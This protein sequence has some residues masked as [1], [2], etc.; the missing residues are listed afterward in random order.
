M[1]QPRPHATLTFCTCVY[2]ASIELIAASHVQDQ[3]PLTG[4]LFDTIVVV[5]IPHYFHRQQYVV[6]A[7]KYVCVFTLMK[8]GCSY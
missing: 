2:A 6:C 1:S 7:E 5:T 8:G 4:T 3:H